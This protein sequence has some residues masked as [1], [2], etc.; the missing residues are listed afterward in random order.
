MR[1]VFSHRALDTDEKLKV[2]LE[3]PSNPKYMPLDASTPLI[4]SA[5]ILSRSP[6]ST[7]T[8]HLDTVSERG[9]TTSMD[10]SAVPIQRS[11]VTSGV[12]IEIPSFSGTT[13]PSNTT[14]PEVGDEKE[15]S[16][17]TRYGYR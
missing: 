16:F 1:I 12:N 13:P 8:H 14:V 5:E 9:S 11:S 15:P 3:G 4:S 2:V 10:S 7:R 6:K 17:E